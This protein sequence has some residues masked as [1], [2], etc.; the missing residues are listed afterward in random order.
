M[1]PAKLLLCNILDK[2]SVLIAGFGLP[3]LRHEDDPVRAVEC[4]LEMYAILQKMQIPCSIGITSK[5]IR[6]L[7]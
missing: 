5:F 3:P 4:A 6:N 7:F 2:G 1:V